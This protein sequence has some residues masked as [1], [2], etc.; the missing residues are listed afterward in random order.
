MTVHFMP[1]SHVSPAILG[2]HAPIGPPCESPARQQ[3][4]RYLGAP[5]PW[6]SMHT[7]YA[8]QAGTE[9][10]AGPDAWGGGKF[11]CLKKETQIHGFTYTYIHIEASI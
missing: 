7:R 9:S 10:N 5:S 1:R 3:G 2:I 4:S 8:L 6:L 11:S